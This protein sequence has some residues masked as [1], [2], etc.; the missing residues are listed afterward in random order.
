MISVA[1]EW[2]AAGEH[3]RRARTRRPRC[4]RDSSTRTFRIS[5]RSHGDEMGA[6]LP[7]TS[8]QFEEA[9][10]H[11]RH[12]HQC[13]GLKHVPRSLA[14]KVAACKL[15][16]LRFD[17]GDELVEGGICFLLARRRAAL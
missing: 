5:L 2:C 9:N 6:V 11:L 13:R 17:Q 14:P 12:F 7:V 1:G 10:E 15:P 16:Q 8:R 4:R 3:L